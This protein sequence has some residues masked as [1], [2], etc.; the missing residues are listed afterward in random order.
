MSIARAVAVAV[1]EQRVRAVK[2]GLVE[3]DQA[4]AVAVAIE[5]PG[6]EAKVV[7]VTVRTGEPLGPVEAR[8]RVVLETELVQGRLAVHPHVEP[9]GFVVSANGESR[10][11]VARQLRYCDEVTAA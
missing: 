6:R 2:L 5:P 9:L 3:I 8:H 4:V 7:E 11:S 1:G 10:E